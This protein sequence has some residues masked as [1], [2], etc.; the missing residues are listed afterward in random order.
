[1]SVSPEFKG[2]APTYDMGRPQAVWTTFVADLETPV[3]TMLKLA[4][5]RANSFLLES[6]SISFYLIDK[7]FEF[8]SHP[9]S[10]G[11]NV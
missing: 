6:V 4:E 10:V 3:S 1:M 5:G 9:A 2:F 8:L 7:T 11:V